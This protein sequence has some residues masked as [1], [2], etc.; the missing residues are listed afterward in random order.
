MIHLLKT[1]GNSYLS[2][3][4]MTKFEFKDGL[5]YFKGLLYIPQRLTQ[6]KIIQM[7]HDLSVAGHFDFNKTMEL[8]SQKFW[9]PQ[10]WKLVKEFIQSCDT[11]AREKVPQHRPYGLLH[12]LPIPKG[13]WLLLSMDFFTNLPLA[14]G[15]D[16]IFVI[17]DQLTKMAHFIPC[18]KTITREE[19]AK[20]FL[21][22]IYCIHGLPNDLSWTRGLNL[23][24][25]SREDFFNYL[26]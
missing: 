26:V 1:S 19:T 6:F 8:I 3:N 24:P 5:L 12:L 10:M 23:L 14:N 11:C 18:T 25:I 2:M 9:L 4:S 15:K 7:H 13:P 21:D 22:N 16:L 20:L 17:V